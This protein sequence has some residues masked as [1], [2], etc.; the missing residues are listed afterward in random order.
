LNPANRRR[1]VLAA[2]EWSGARPPTSGKVSVQ[3]G[4]SR[5]CLVSRPREGKSCETACEI[6]QF[7]S[8]QAASFCL[9]PP[10]APMLRILLQL[11]QVNRPHRP[12]ILRLL[13][14]RKM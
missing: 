13:L 11:P 4:K 12:R 5:S 1:I 10:C 7:L 9:R 14:L 3:V 6:G 2:S 8:V